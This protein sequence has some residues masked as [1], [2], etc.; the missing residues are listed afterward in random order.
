MVELTGKVEKS[1]VGEQP[2]AKVEEQADL[3]AK[4]EEQAEETRCCATGSRS[5]T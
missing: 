1:R 5:R 2:A 3:A 4:V